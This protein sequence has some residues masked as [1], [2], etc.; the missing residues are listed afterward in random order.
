MVRLG[1]TVYAFEATCPHAGARLVT[2]RV[3][4]GCLECPVHGA[5]FDLAKGGVVR[6]PARRRLLVYDVRVRAGV[7]YV[8]DRPRRRWRAR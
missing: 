8:A 5:R 3:V 2:G 4:G 6:G 7:V 1:G